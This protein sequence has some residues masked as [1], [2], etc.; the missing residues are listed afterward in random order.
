MSDLIKIAACDPGK[1]R[2][3]FGFVII[4]I[5]DRKI[6]VRGAERWHG[7]PYKKIVQKIVQY[8]DEL[9]FDKIVVEQNHVG[10]FLIEE[11]ELEYHTPVMPVVTSKN[12][13][14]EK[15]RRQ[16]KTM[17]K[18]EMVNFIASLKQKHRIRF[19]T[20]GSKDMQEL[21]RQISIF[22]EHRTESG[23]ISYYAEGNE[24]DDL[25]MALMLACFAARPYLKPRTKRIV[26]TKDWNQHE[27]DDIFRSDLPPGAISTG[28][29]VYYPG[30][31]TDVRNW[32]VR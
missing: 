30:G 26:V 16:G 10:E 25:V 29:D 28:M 4:E 15:I 14:S 11:F 18:N 5:K 9:E 2:D 20:H 8:N 21:K 23:Q 12:L 3:S 22:A 7:R 32:R 24:H 13:K 1:I 6:L 31:V 27:D 17:D 19:R